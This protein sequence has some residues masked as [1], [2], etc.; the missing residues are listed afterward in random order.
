MT[1]D[2]TGGTEIQQKA[3]GKLTTSRFEGLVGPVAVG[4]L[5]CTGRVQI[6]V[7]KRGR[8]CLGTGPDGPKTSGHFIDIS[9]AK[10]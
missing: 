5:H 1:D 3:A 10:A 6:E 4:Q 7:G 8:F 2:Q 9:G